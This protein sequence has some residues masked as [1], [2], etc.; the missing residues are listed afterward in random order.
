MQ[1][2]MQAIGAYGYLGLVKDHKDSYNMFRKQCA[3]CAT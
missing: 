3:H 1:R 2:L